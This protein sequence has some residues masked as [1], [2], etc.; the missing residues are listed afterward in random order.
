MARPWSR[1]LVEAIEAF[2][3][4]WTAPACRRCDCHVAEAAAEVNALASS[5]LLP[6]AAV[7][8]AFG[9]RP[10]VFAGAYHAMTALLA[11]EP[12]VEQGLS[13]VTNA[14]ELATWLRRVRRGARADDVDAW[15]REHIRTAEAEQ[16]ASSRRANQ[17][18]STGRKALARRRRSGLPAEERPE[19]VDGGIDISSGLD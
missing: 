1:S 15:V 2:D 10:H 5:G 17:R 16:I 9:R 8:V 12:L 4:G 7:L 18:T 13:M 11:C 14:Q 19:P 3:R 6:T